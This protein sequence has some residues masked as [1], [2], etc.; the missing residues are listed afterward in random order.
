[1]SENY[2]VKIYLQFSADFPI[3]LFF[4]FRNLFILVQFLSLL[5]FSENLV[6]ILVQVFSLVL[7][8]FFDFQFSFFELI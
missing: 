6:E 4:D 2:T 5:N 8:H 7:Y 1:M 3:I